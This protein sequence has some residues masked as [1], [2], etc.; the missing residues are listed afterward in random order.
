MKSSKNERVKEK[1]KRKLEISATDV[2]EYVKCPAFF[3]QY[4]SS[5]KRLEDCYDKYYHDII[6]QTGK[7]YELSEMEKYYFIENTQSLTDLLHNKTISVIRIKPGT[8]LKRKI[9]VSNEK[10]KQFNKIYAIGRPDLIIREKDTNKFI[11]LDYKTSL[12][13]FNSI[14]FQLYHY[15]YILQEYD[16]NIPY[17]GILKSGKLDTFLL[18][19]NILDLEWKQIIN[20]IILIKGG[21]FSERKIIRE[22][23][24]W[25]KECR[26]CLFNSVC[27]KIVKSNPTIKDLPEVKK[28]RSQIINSLGIKSLEELA[29]TNPKVLWEK[30]LKIPDGKVVFNSELTVKQIIGTARAFLEKK[31]ILLSQNLQSLNIKTNDV[32]FDSE[33]ISSKTNPEV[34]SISLGIIKSDEF[35]LIK[36][37]FAN[38]ISQGEK[39]LSSF[40]DYLNNKGVKRVFGW[41]IK[42]GGELTQLNKISPLPPEIS[43][44]DLYYNIKNN[45]AMPVLSYSLKSV[46]KFLFGD[47]FQ[48]KIKIGLAA[49]GL[50]GKFLN[51]G[52]IEYKESIIEYNKKDVLQTYEIACWYERFCKEYN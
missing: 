36:N 11:P 20:S 45:M 43:F 42:A 34:F 7:D 51:T 6:F 29:K 24:R 19:L 44:H 14:R 47:Q 31:I 13:L 50:Y 27:E 10:S 41:G 18:N 32:F 15:C 3:K 8:I 30:I 17:L 25:T 33:Y 49:I 40:Y 12:S 2:F 48:D 46:S 28:R 39:I 37:W 35:L 22:D 1:I 26:K 5:G 52:N 4:V 16:A 21:G 23:I 38:S 9:Y